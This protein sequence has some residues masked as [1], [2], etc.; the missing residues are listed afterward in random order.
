MIELPCVGGGGN[1]GPKLGVENDLGRARRGE[2]GL[3]L[4]KNR[5]GEFGGNDEGGNGQNHREVYV[6]FQLIGGCRSYLLLR[7]DVYGTGGI[8]SLMG[9]GFLLSHGYDRTLSRNG[10]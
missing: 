8:R 6:R 2:T 9:G 10:S 5:C 7:G 1:S 3:F 4:K